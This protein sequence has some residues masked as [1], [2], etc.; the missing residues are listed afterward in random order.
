MN[1]AAA[2]RLFTSGDS[3]GPGAVGVSKYNVKADA[4]SSDLASHH[5]MDQPS[6]LD[7]TQIRWREKRQVE[8]SIGRN[9][10]LYEFLP[11]PST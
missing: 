9:L 5:S 2:I 8:H 4:S 3:M 1:L 11:K 7:Q 10:E 6:A